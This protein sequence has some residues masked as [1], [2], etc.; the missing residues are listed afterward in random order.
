MVVVEKISFWRRVPC[1]WIAVAVISLVGAVVIDLTT[2][3]SS[4][5]PFLA[6]SPADVLEYV[7]DWK[8][9]LCA[10]WQSKDNHF[11]ELHVGQA[12]EIHT[13]YYSAIRWGDNWHPLPENLFPHGREQ[14]DQRFWSYEAPPMADDDVWTPPFAKEVS[15]VPSHVPVNPVTIPCIHPDPQQEAAGDWY[16]I[17]WY[18]GPAYGEGCDDVDSEQFWEKKQHQKKTGA[19][20]AVEDDQWIKDLMRGIN[21][22]AEVVKETAGELKNKVV[23]QARKSMAVVES[24]VSATYEK[25]GEVVDGVVDRFDEVVDRTGEAVDYWVDKATNWLD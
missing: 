16:C 17:W 3:Q 15:F 20:Y 21:S 4:Q 24:K 18:R 11:D 9:S 19:G 12:A 8:E 25:V 23:H 6:T 5:K 7:D 10:K 13:V 2:S 22:K 14:G 1:N